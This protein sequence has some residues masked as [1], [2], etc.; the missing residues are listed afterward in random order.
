MKNLNLKFKT[1]LAGGSFSGGFGRVSLGKFEGNINHPSGNDRQKEGNKSPG[2]SIPN[3][4]HNF[5]LDRFLNLKAM[6]K[7][8]IPAKTSPVKTK[9]LNGDLNSKKLGTITIAPNQP[10]ARL[11]K[12]SDNTENQTLS[13]A[14]MNM[15][16]T[17][18]NFTVNGDRESQSK[19]KEDSALGATGG[20]FGKKIVKN[21]KSYDSQCEGDLSLDYSGRKVDHNSSKNVSVFTAK[22]KENIANNKSIVNANI[23]L[24]ASIAPNQ[25]TTRLA[26]TDE[27][28]R[29]LGRVNSKEYCIKNNLSEVEFCVK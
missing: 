2:V 12:N 11:I 28:T 14:S 19:L 23:S 16:I 18:T 5:L 15:T 3:I 26:Q 13:I 24:V 20:L 22:S 1:D 7:L 21:S 4:N 10:A 6:N 25:S 17:G 9:K 29:S 8:N 27:N